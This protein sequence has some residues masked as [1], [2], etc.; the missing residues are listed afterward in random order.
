MWLPQWIGIFKVQAPPKL[1]YLMTVLIFFPAC[2]DS[3][4]FLEMN[5]RRQG[6]RKAYRNS[7]AWIFRHESYEKWMSG[8]R[9]LLWVIGKPGS[10]KSTLMKKVLDSF[11][12]H[13]P[14]QQ[15]RLY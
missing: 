2:L 15:L 3:L 1:V 13:K 9:G 11:D 12:E 6:I 4:G 10:G 7:C 14:Q 8:N 5:F